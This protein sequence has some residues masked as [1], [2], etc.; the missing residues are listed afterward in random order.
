MGVV[1][2]LVGVF[3]MAFLDTCVEKYKMQQNIKKLRTQES[4]EL[5]ASQKSQTDAAKAQQA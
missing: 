5:A 1:L 4:M 2:G 3:F